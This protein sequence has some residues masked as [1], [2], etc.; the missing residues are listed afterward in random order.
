LTFG[1]DNSK[2]YFSSNRP[3]GHG[4]DDIYSFRDDGIYLEGI[5]VDAQTGDPICTSKV[6]MIAK[7]EIANENN[8]T[9]EC[10]GEFEFD[11]V[12]DLDYCFEAVADGY[13]PNKS[14]CATTKGT[15]PGDKV[16]VKIPLEKIKA[17]SLNVL[18]RD[19]KT[20]EPIASAKVILSGECDGIAQN[21]ESDA[22]GLSCYTVKCECD[23]IAIANANGY[24]PGTSTGTTKDKCDQL[25]KCGEA[26]GVTIIVELDKLP[27]PGDQYANGSND[28]GFIE[29]KDIY[30]DFDKWNI[31][32]ESKPQLNILLGF[33]QENPA[34]IVEIASH[35]DA[36]AP[37]DYNIRLSQKRAQSVV[38]WLV[39]HGIDRSRLKPKGY[40]E[41]KPRNKC[42][43]NVQCSEY[44]H[45]RNRRTEFRVISG[46]IDVKS[47]ERVDMQVDPCKICPF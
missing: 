39:S 11:V 36:R 43:D 1:K 30:Y 21:G 34:A 12:R 31:R 24:L 13:M 41:T 37:S 10:D 46:T 29:L 4:L 7:S 23:F 47:L 35:T 17:G 6:K 16:F 32:E 33:L 44:E 25:V 42:S 45:Q 14:V 38:D 2:G 3:G 20:Q 18:V 9:T 22:N 5:V 26:G 15:N 19:K 28:S 40:G 27:A 8:T